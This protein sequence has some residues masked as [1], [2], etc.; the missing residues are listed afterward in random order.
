[1]DWHRHRPGADLIY[2]MQIVRGY[3][4][5]EGRRPHNRICVLFIDYTQKDALA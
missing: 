4:D 3:F 2:Q 1:M 5:F